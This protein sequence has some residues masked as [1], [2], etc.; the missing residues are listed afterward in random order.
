MEY[1]AT[2]DNRKGRVITFSLPEPL[3]LGEYEGFRLPINNEV[4]LYD[5]H[6]IDDDVTIYNFVLKED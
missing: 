4:Y 6:S 1:K 5:S 2:C 3:P